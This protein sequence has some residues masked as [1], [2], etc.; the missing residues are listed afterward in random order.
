MLVCLFLAQQPLLGHGLLIHEVPRSQRPPPNN[1]K[2]SR[3]TSMPPVGFEPTISAGEWLQTYAI[4]HAAT[5][6][7]MKTEN[8]LWFLLPI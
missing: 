5:G 2:H 6:T 7:S 4:D 3:Q 1:T 8:G